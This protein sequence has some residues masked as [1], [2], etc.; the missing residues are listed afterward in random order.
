MHLLTK[1]FYIQKIVRISINHVLFDV[2]DGD[3]YFYLAMINLK[4]YILNIGAIF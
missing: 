2:F 4:P 1:I 3:A